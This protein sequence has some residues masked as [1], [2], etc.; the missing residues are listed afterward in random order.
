MSVVAKR[1][2]RTRCH[3][4]WI[5][6]GHIVL[7]WDAAPPKGTQQSPSFRSMS[8]VAKR[9]PISATAELLLFEVAAGQTVAVVLICVQHHVLLH[10]NKYF[11]QLH[12]K[13]P[14]Q[15]F[16]R[17]MHI[18]L[19]IHSAACRLLWPIIVCPTVAVSLRLSHSDLAATAEK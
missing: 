15:I 18:Q 2:D 8:I 12:L 11:K 19:H 3:L 5:G 4:V 10:A 14:E 17:M 13:S 16:Y 9:S 1:Q 6:S 7:D